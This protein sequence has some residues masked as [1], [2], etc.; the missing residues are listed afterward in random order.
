MNLSLCKRRCLRKSR[1]SKEIP[2]HGTIEG[3]Y[4]QVSEPFITVDRVA[5]HWKEKLRAKVQEGLKRPITKL[6]WS[7]G[8]FARRFVEATKYLS[9]ASQQDLAGSRV[10]SQINNHHACLILQ[11][12]R[13]KSKTALWNYRGKYLIHC[14]VKLLRNTRS[15]TVLWIKLESET[16]NRLSP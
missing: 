3:K 16:D 5:I 6:S 1:S 9:A 7:W 13:R 15:K 10:I 12:F 14:T 4:P 11:I 2:R 8:Y